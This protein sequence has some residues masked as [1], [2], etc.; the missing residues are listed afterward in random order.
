MA[1]PRRS[2]VPVS[3]STARQ[4]SSCRAR[5]SFM[6][7]G[8]RSPAL[9]ARSV[10]AR[11]RTLFGAVRLSATARSMVVS[12]IRS[13]ACSARSVRPSPTAM[14]RRIAGS[15]MRASAARRIMG[16]AAFR[17]TSRSTRS[18][19]V[20]ARAACRMVSCAAV[21]AI[22]ARLCSSE[23]HASAA[24]HS[25]SDPS[26]LATAAR[27]SRARSV[28][29]ARKSSSV[30]PWASPSSRSGSSSFL[31]AIRRTR[32][33]GS[34]RAIVSRRVWSRTP[35]SRTA[36]ARTSGSDRR[37]RGRSRSRISIALVLDSVYYGAG[38]VPSMT[39]PGRSALSPAPRPRGPA[40]DDESWNVEP[41]EIL[42]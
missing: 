12:V 25:A 42:G 20:R 30:S 38:R 17:T 26:E 27:I 22:A 5:P 33:S 8:S 35:I 23:R 24:S 2:R 13:S 19:V 39:P 6:P 15:S 7:I 41:L 36:A 16:S 10:R 34:L 4:S 1:A 37:H 14:L 28:A 21:I 40:V 31:M 11:W 29:K 9:V 3:F 32:A 18:P